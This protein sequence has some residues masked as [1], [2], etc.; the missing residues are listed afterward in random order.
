[1]SNIEAEANK[2][3]GLFNF[4]E[5]QFKYMILLLYTKNTLI[6]PFQLTNFVQFLQLCLIYEL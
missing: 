2:K 3:K 6:N 5:I 1:M 4:V